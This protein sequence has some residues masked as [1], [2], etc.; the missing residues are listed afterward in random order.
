MLS[1]QLWDS[2]DPLP[3][4]QFPHLSKATTLMPVPRLSARIVLLNITVHGIRVFTR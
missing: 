2:G 1:S 4:Y 3:R